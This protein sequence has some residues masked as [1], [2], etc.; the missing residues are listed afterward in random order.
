MR[1][2]KK[3]NRILFLIIMLLGLTI[4]YAALSTTLKIDGL[5][6][7]SKN[8]WSV[9]WNNPVVNPKSVTPT[10]IPVIGKEEND[11]DNTLVTWS[12]RL[13]KPGDFYEFTVDAVNAGSIDAMITNIETTVTPSLPDFINGNVEGDALFTILAKNMPKSFF[14][15]IKS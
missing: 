11:E 10:N 8:T 7:I 9:Y 12:T 13:T 2:Y 6:T 4:G 1:R 15:S 5:T 3:R 14:P